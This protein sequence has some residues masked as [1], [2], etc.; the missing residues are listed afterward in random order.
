MAS[1][2]AIDTDA[3]PSSSSKATAVQEV[4]SFDPDQFVRVLQLPAL[5]IRAQQ[6]GDLQKDGKLKV[7][8]FRQRNTRNVL[9]CPRDPS[10][11][12]IL[13]QPETTS[14]KLPPSVQKLLEAGIATFESFELKLGYEQTTA[15]EVLQ[16]LLPKGVDI[17]RGFE[18][19]GHLAHFNLKEQQWPYRK[20]IGKVIMDK[21]PSIKTVI[22]KVGSLYNEFRTFDMEVI[23]GK[24]DT[25]VSVNERQ[26]KLNFDFREVYWNSRLSEERVRLLDQ[27]KPE[28]IILDLF[29]GVG[30]FACMCAKE[31]CEVYA[32]DLNPAGAAA[33]RKNAETNRLD[34]EVY[35]LD[36]RACVREFA[37]LPPLSSRSEGSS[38]PKVHVIMNLPELAL[39]FLDA[40][41]EMAEDG[42]SRLFSGSALEL[43]IHCHCFAREKDHPELE[44]NP[45]ILAALGHVPSK[46]RYREVRDVA[47]KKNMYCVEF[48]LDLDANDEGAAAAAKRARVGPP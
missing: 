45:R 35:N 17:P 40:F 15:E 32:N 12:V 26:L 20:V 30:A 47:P 46:I 11:R 31:G 23:A 37:S 25:K 2:S 6:V 34:F 14:E 36:A 3:C 16:Q 41:R 21:N 5:R 8:F 4:E 24:D 33:M 1:E 22:T 27:V 29:A 39:D 42:K 7:M 44:I 10:Y 19:V 28:D 9:P 13:L 48:C 18:T 43:H 38:K